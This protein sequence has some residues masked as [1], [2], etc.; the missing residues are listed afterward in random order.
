MLAVVHALRV[1]RCNLKGAVFTDHVSNT[2]FQTQPCLSRRQA[3]W[4]EFQQR[5]GVC[6]W[7][8]C[9]GGWNVADILSR[10]AMYAPCESITYVDSA[11]AQHFGAVF[12]PTDVATSSRGMFQS[13]NQSGHTRSVLGHQ[14]VLEPTFDLSSS[15]L[16]PLIVGS[17]E[18]CEKPAQFAKMQ[19]GRTP[20]N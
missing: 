2:F 4:S 19:T 15:L 5:F 1:W 17:K 13:S 7:E 8:Y 3:R 12:A 16:K 10:K 9:K 18:L 14:I 6:K 20:T 11:K